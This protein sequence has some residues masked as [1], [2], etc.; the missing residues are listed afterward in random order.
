MPPSDGETN[1]TN[2]SR[3]IPGFL[4]VERGKIG[5]AVSWPAKA[6]YGRWL[7][8]NTEHFVALHDGRINAG[9]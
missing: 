8:R 2:V 4:P 5:V 1:W 6:A 9:A 7:K 3:P